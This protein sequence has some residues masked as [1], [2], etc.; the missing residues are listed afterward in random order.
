V[1]PGYNSRE[2]LSENCELIMDFNYCRKARS[3]ADFSINLAFCILSV[4]S[5]T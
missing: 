3:A 4:G 2:N 1:S 5:S